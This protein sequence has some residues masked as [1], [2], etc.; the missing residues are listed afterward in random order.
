MAVD[1]MPSSQMVSSLPLQILFYF[2]GWWDVLYTFI[3]FARPSVCNQHG[4]S[5]APAFCETRRG[6]MRA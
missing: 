2:N 3:M 6:S 4:T 5:S 1:P